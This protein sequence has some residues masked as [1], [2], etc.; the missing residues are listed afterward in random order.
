MDENRQA[1]LLFPVRRR[2]MAYAAAYLTGV[3][4]A[5]LGVYNPNVSVLLCALS[6]PAG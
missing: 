2:L 3:A 6:V 5:G 4:L 1:L